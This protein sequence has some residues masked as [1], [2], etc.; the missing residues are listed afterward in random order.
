MKALFFLKQLRR[1]D[2]SERGIL[3]NRKYILLLYALSVLSNYACQEVV[4]IDL[5]KTD[6]HIVIEGVI[7][8][9][10]GPYSVKV[11]KT[12]NYFEPSLTFPPVSHALIIIT[13]DLGQQD[14]LNEITEGN[15]TTSHLQG[16]EGRTYSLSVTA[17][18]QTYNAMTSMPVKVSID[19]LSATP[20]KGF[21]G[22][23]GFDINV[24]FQDPSELGNY[25]RINA[26]SSTLIPS[27]SI[28]GRRYRLYSDKYT[29]GNEMNVRIRS[30]GNVKRGDTITVELLTI[31]KAAYDY[32]S[33]LRDALTS[34]RAPTS[35]S[36][37][38]PNTNLNN[39]SLGYF[40]AFTLDRKSI[41]IK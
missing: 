38:N 1:P 39:G 12:G 40:A 37:T 31:D 3:W 9:Q 30:G 29:N 23:A 15:Y 25:Y 8:D 5:N 24:V 16:V 34:D 13:N 17:E 14:T 18:G 33:T 11:S 27:D 2:K 28:D 21:R 20:R 6:P 41:V 36:P 26:R 35:L 22:E 7:T 10:Q 32:F 4:S 19:S